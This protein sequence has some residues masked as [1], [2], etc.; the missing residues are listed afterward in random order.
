MI[1]PS[2][3]L[4]LAS[5]ELA[6]DRFAY[7]AYL[8]EHLPVHRARIL[9]IK[10]MVTARYEDCLT[11]VKDDRF[12][13]NRATVTGGSRMPFPLPKGIQFLAENMI[14]SDDPEHKRL[15]KL[16]QPAFAPKK[17][18]ALEE[19]VMQRAH[20]LLDECLAEPEVDLQ[21]AFALPIPAR[22]IGEMVGVSDDDMDRFQHSVRVLS[23][24]LSGWSILRTVAWDLRKTVEFMREIIAKKKADPGDDLISTLLEPDE[25]GDKLTDDELVGLIF[26][27]IVAGYE[28]TVHLISNGVITLLDHPDEM[29]RL[30]ENPQLMGS[31]VEEI[32]RFAGPVH[33]TKMNYAN[34]DIE[35]RGVVIPKGTACMPLL[36]SANRDDSVFEDPDRFD[37]ARDP[38]KHL[39][40]SQ[41]KHFCLGAFLARMEAKIAFQ[42][43]LERTKAIDLAV[44]RD[45]L[46]IAPMPGWYR[47]VGVPVK[48]HAA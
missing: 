34:E 12:L 11:V 42:V 30:R 15:R 14:N 36:G 20:G 25:E 23:Q 26:L 40:F 38:N 35:M 43:L 27:L 9:G 2:K 22:V 16:V 10:L 4:N 32:L 1:D 3:P 6:A 31:A 24:G 48:L 17:I 28:T 39:S 21:Q 41:G 18:H 7:Y 33:G 46:K 8:R 13:R 44:G 19:R 45:E 37:I 47:H 5:K 29:A